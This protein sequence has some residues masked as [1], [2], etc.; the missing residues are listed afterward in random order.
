VP[1]PPPGTPGVAADPSFA[2]G[3]VE[4]ARLVRE[5]VRHLVARFGVEEVR[6]SPLHDGATA[7]SHYDGVIA[8]PHHDDVITSPHHA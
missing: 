2:R 1:L 7:S 5:S 4:Y 6:A 8:A 3:N